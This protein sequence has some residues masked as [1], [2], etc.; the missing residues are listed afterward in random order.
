M[1]LINNGGYVEVSRVTLNGSTSGSIHLITDLPHLEVTPHIGLGQ[2]V[3][4]DV[5]AVV[6]G[7]VF[8]VLSEHTGARTLDNFD[9]PELA[10]LPGGPGEFF[11]II[12]VGPTDPSGSFSTSFTI[13]TNDPAHQPGAGPEDAA[14]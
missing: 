1:A 9:G 4:V 7:D 3:Q 6:P 11:A 14:R 8:L 2:T 5:D 12:P 10:A 13:P